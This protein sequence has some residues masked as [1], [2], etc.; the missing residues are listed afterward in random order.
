MLSKHAES[1]GVGLWVAPRLPSPELVSLMRGA[2]AIVSMAHKESFG[3]TPIEAFA[4]GTPPLFVDEGGFRDTIVDGENGRLLDRG[5]SASWH[6]ALEQASDPDT[7]EGWAA[8]GR[9]RISE[10]DLTPD[11]HARRI[12]DLLR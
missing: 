2:R 7:R 1:H 11:A 10:L 4:V 3:L 8:S 5:D 6:S 12:R 9:G